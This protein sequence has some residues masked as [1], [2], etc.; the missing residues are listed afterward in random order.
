MSASKKPEITR[1]FR[2]SF[3]AFQINCFQRLHQYWI[4][5]GFNSFKSSCSVSGCSCERGNLVAVKCSFYK[6]KLDAVDASSAFID[7]VWK[8][9][10]VKTV[11]QGQRG[12]KVYRYLLGLFALLFSFRECF[13][14]LVSLVNLIQS[15]KV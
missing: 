11:T 1:S 9:Q 12:D 13:R 14:E 2:V 8:W 3:R 4:F 6:T 10:C 5:Q 7:R 15:N